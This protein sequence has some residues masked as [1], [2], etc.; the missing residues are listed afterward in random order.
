MRKEI[1][2]YVRKCDLCQRAKPAKNRRVGLHA[3]DPVS[4]PMER[5]FIDFV[6]PLTRTKRGNVA[7]LVT[8]DSFSKFVTLYPVRKI[9][10]R[11]ALD[12]LERNYFPAYGTPKSVVTDNARIFCGKEFKDLCFKWG[13]QHI[14]TTPYYPQASLAERVNR[15]LKSALKIFHHESQEKWDEDLVWIGRAF[16]TAVHEST[17]MTPDLLFLGREMKGP[18]GVR[19]DLSPVYDNPGKGADQSFW[20]E[21]Y[22]NLLAAKRRV[23]RRHNKSRRPHNYGVG[24]LVR[25]QLKGSSSKARN[26]TSKLMLR[27]SAPVVVTKVVG[28]NT[29]LLANPDSGVIVRRAHVTQLKPC[30]N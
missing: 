10:A 27:W 16:N 3:A 6:G 15:N 18:L 29:V 12:C 1:I 11:A 22:R 21:A 5:L 28:P 13:I 7:I 2:E 23:E 4:Q 9:A 19:W 14:T 17:R 25:Y 26:I 20:T 30:V 8:V 24:D